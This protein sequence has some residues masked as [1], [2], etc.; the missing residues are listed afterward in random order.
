MPPLD[1]A[2]AD[3]QTLLNSNPL[4]RIT[5]PDAAQGHHGSWTSKQIL[6]H[7]IDSAANNHHR[8]VRA[9][10]EPGFSMPGYA[11]EPWVETQHYRDRPWHELVTLWTAYNRHL[12]FLME[13]VPQHSRANTCRI[14]SGDPVT[15]EFL[16]VDYVRH[17][18]HHLD[19]ILA[20]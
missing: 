16:M 19:Q 8:F 9:Q 12:L 20:R 4:A 2:I 6:G 1:S 5:E 13:Q 17:L 11:Q 3:F 14:G 7:L 15:L 18:K 10:I